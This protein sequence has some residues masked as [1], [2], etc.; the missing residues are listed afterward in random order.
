VVD[1][2]LVSTHGTRLLS[3]DAELAFKKTLLPFAYLVTPN[4]PEAEL[5]TGLT[6][7]SEHDKRRAA[8]MFLQWGCKAALIKGGHSSGEP[9]DYLLT[10]SSW[11]QFPGQRVETK[12]THGTGCVYSAAITACLAQGCSL[13]EAVKVSREFIQTAIETAPCL[14][15]GNGPVNFFAS[16]SEFKEH[17]EG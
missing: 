15:R 11:L 7:E 1:P 14:G 13:V 12:H 4:I 8:E 5:L 17:V 6:I 2:V 9:V 3:H 10:E 16:V